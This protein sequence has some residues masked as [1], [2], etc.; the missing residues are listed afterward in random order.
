MINDQYLTVF[1]TET[2]CSGL[3]CSDSESTHVTIW[4]LHGELSKEAV[5]QLL[6]LSI[7]SQMRLMCCLSVAWVGRMF[8]RVLDFRVKSCFLASFTSVLS[9][10]RSYISTTNCSCSSSNIDHSLT[11]LGMHRSSLNASF[12]SGKDFQ[13]SQAVFFPLPANAATVSHPVK[14]CSTGRVRHCVGFIVATIS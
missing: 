12:T 5:T 6:H 3:E 7:P 2:Q 8:S 9:L 14:A 1:T 4:M 13:V 10:V 11:S